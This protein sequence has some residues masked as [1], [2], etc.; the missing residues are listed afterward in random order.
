MLIRLTLVSRLTILYALI[1]ALVLC[2]LGVMVA[3]AS[4]LHFVDLDLAYLQGKAS[5]VQRG[6]AQTS[7][8]SAVRALLAQ[9]MD[10]HEGLYIALSDGPSSGPMVQGVDFSALSTAK[11]PP[12]LLMTG[13][14]VT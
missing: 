14:Q 12:R 1:S 5:L 10:S 9:Q 3:R 13:K 7:E 2:G 8:P 6:L 11:V 4:Y